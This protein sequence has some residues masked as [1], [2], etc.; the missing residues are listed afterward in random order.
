M[1]N[2]LVSAGVACLMAAVIGGGLKAFS[3][4]V[5]L[6]AALHRQVLLAV[7]G[8]GLLGAAIWINGDSEDHDAPAAGV[9]PSQASPVSA[10]TGEPPPAEGHPSVSTASPARAAP[11]EL[12]K[13]FIPAS[14]QPDQSARD[15]ECQPGQV[16]HVKWIDE[17]AYQAV[18]RL[19][20]RLPNDR[21][22]RALSLIEV[23]RTGTGL[24]AEQ[25]LLR[26]RDGKAYWQDPTNVTWTE[27]VNDSPDV[28]AGRRGVLLRRQDPDQA[29]VRSRQLLEA[30]IPTDISSEQFT[31]GNVRMCYRWRDFP[32]DDPRP[33]NL[34]PSAVPFDACVGRIVRVARDR[35]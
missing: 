21:A 17:A 25:S 30:F 22:N 34:A 16:T 31:E 19:S 7:L 28:V 9:P 2:I 20:G 33:L 12:C 27:I 8:L 24:W 3:I 6:L 26:Y 14:D 23:D 11:G 4:E 10:E 35:D 13:P 15:R 29:C 1:V 18:D 5:P 32:C